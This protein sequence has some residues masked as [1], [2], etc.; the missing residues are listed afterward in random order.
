MHLRILKGEDI[1]R[2]LPLNSGSFTIGRVS[3]NSFQIAEAGVSRLHCTLNNVDGQWL[4]E[5]NQSVNGVLVNGRRI[6]DHIFLHA[7]DEITVFSHVFKLEEEDNVMAPLPSLAPLSEPVPDVPAPTPLMREEDGPAPLPT[8]P[9]A[10]ALDEYDYLV[11]RAE[12]KSAAAQ[13]VKIAVM[14][15]LVVIIGVIV[16]KLIPSEKP[17]LETL[18]VEQASTVAVTPGPATVA[19]RGEAISTQQAVEGVTVAAAPTPTP[20]PAAA[21]GEPAAVLTEMKEEEP[22]KPV[23]PAKAQPVTMVV[24]TEPRGADVLL[25]GE[26]VGT[27]PVVLKNL[28]PEKSQTLEIA[29]TGYERLV[30]QVRAAEW[31][32]DAPL[33]LIPK[34][35]T[36][37]VTSEPAGAQVRL[38]RIVLGTTPLIVPEMRSGEHELTFELNGYETK[39]QKVVK[40]PARGGNVNVSLNKLLGSVEISTIPAGCDV[41]LDGLLLGNTQAQEGELTSEPLVVEN[42]TPGNATLKVVHPETQQFDNNVIVIP[43]NGV[44]KRKIFLWIPTHKVILSDGNTTVGMMMKQHDDE[45]EMITVDNKRERFVRQAPDG[46]LEKGTYLYKELHDIL[47]D[48]R[49]LI[50][51]N[52]ASGRQPS[53]Q[54]STKSKLS[55]SA[56]TFLERANY[57]YFRG[58]VREKLCITGDVTSRLK[59]PRGTWIQFGKQIRCLLAPNA[60]EDDYKKIGEL[61]RN[62]QQVSLRGIYQGPDKDNVYVFTDCVLLPYPD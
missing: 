12:K 18:E 60:S 22:A 57:V 29:K 16:M 55:I 37:F 40:E 11:E 46:E 19:G 32:A 59:T 36:F 26:H 47:P 9:R 62:K 23:R 49:A 48:D 54:M 24:D 27:T 52:R 35:Q 15:V 31:S 43:R 14:V 34:A 10:S 33:R 3:D 45:F 50:L 56:E 2:I 58:Y 8:P 25:N 17:V 4:L 41:Y 1:G 38:G 6:T 13:L 28:A 20:K 7:G 44:L 39:I 21:K 5:D 51:K 61:S 30:K 53:E 42:I